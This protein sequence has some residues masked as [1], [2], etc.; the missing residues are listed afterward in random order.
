MPADSLPVEHLFTLTAKVSRVATIA[1][2][3]AGTRVIVNCTSGEFEGRGMRGTVVSPSGDW[4]TVRPDGSL[5]VDVRLLLRTDDG[6]DILMTY[7]GIAT[8]DAI[9]TAP[10]FE[11]GDER[12][13]WLNATQAVATGTS[14]GGQVTYEIYRLV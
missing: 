7:N 4:V 9:R 14:G 1:G 3:P 11:T 10:V 13:A 5:R 6:A 2:G 12:Y 8:G